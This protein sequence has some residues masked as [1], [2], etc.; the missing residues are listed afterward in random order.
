M[1]KRP[2]VNNRWIETHPAGF[3]I[4]TPDK[5]SDTIPIG[6]PVCHSLVRNKDDEVSWEKFQCCHRCKLEW[7]ESRKNEWLNGWRPNLEIVQEKINDRPPIQI[8]LSVDN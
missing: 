2:Y 4:I 5:M 8:N 3:V 7:A 1:S 6:C